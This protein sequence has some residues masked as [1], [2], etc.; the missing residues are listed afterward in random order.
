M[1]VSIGSVDEPVQLC[2][3]DPQWPAQFT[4]EARR[5]EANLCPG[6]RIEHIGST[7]VP[8]LLA[9]PI[10]D[11]MLGLETQHGVNPVRA[12]LASAGYDD[13]GE[14]GVPGR[15]YFRRRAANAY[16][17]HLTLVGGAIWRTN[18]ALREYLRSHPG[19]VIEYA[20]A[21]RAA[22]EKSSARL[23]AYSDYKHDTIRR[24]IACALGQS[25]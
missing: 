15:I 16:N 18:L 12:Q 22:L 7:S 17:V 19:A 21:K 3:Y 24:L 23:L 6:V 1:T 2:P 14:A 5:I 8:G 20:E 11:I 25:L 13:M 10:I 9:K 4:C